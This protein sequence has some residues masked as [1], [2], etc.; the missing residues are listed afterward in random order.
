MQE[1]RKEDLMDK[2]YYIYIITNQTNKVLYI[3][4]TNNLFRRIYEHKEE[5]FEDFSKTY[6]CKKLVWYDK[7][8]DVR[9]EIK[10]E[11]QMK[12]W[13]REFKENVIHQMNPDWKDLY[14]E[15]F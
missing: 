15:L 13:K 8:T 3:G 4:I 9:E 2:I 12:K 10:K 7:T 14:D 11:K 6:K 5:I 1:S